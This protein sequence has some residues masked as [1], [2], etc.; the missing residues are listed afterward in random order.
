MPA[1]ATLTGFA[2]LRVFVII[3]ENEKTKKI[4]FAD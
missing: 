2:A 4:Y 3:L 1:A